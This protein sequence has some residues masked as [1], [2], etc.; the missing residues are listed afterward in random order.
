MKRAELALPAGRPAALVPTGSTYPERRGVARRSPEPDQDETVELTAAGD[1]TFLPAALSVIE[2][3]ASPARA[4]FRWMLATLAAVALAWSY[5]GYLTDYAVLPGRI[6]V[7]GRT[8][9]IEP[10]EVGRVTAIRVVDGDRVNKGDVLVELDATAAA[11]ERT[12]IANKLADL[13]AAT[14]RLNAEIRAARQDPV[15]MSASIV[16]DG[17]IA[18]EVRRREEG[19]FKANLSQLSA[20]LSNL[21]AQR[22]AKEVDRDNYSA[23]I[24]AQKD[25][26][27][28]ISERASMVQDLERQG[29]NSKGNLLAI[30]SAKNAEQVKLTSFE[31]GMAD[32]VA[33]IA[34]LD[35]QIAKAREDFLSADAR[36]LSDTARQL[37]DYQQQLSKATQRLANMTLIAPTGG[38]IHASVLTT[39]GQVVKPAQQLMQIVPDDA[40]LEIQAYLPNTEVGFIKPGQSATIKVDTF[41]F[42]TYGSIPG[43][44]VSVA[45]DALPTSGKNRLESASLDGA[46]MQTSAAQKTGNIQFPIIV[47]A[48]RSYMNVNGKK[49]PLSPGMTVTVEVRT[50]DRRA[51]DY[52]V[53]P[54]LELFSTAG[55]E[56]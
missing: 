4:A 10:S 29:W 7:Q 13:R 6:Q 31:G 56:R 11:A 15:D 38:T 16:W 33:A 47:A 52:I 19:V 40:G 49:V 5:F 39:V 55:H 20:T 3:H 35:S 25:L 9:V 45:A 41:P 28:L 37:S 8:K 48:S 44:V 30:L 46:L 27:S 51:I 18:P 43:H 36:V 53:S 22:R 17:D 12:I 1:R 54:L 26:I 34:V 2:V 42:A 32:A 14:A 21:K 23:N 24:A 50:E